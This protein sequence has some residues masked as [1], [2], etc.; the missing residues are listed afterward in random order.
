MGDFG[1]GENVLKEV[2]LLWFVKETVQQ[3]FTLLVD[4]YSSDAQARAVAQRLSAQ[5]G[6]VDFP[7]AFQ[8]TLFKL[9]RIFGVTDSSATD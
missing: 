7:E 2:H 5:A 9:I 6:F 3:D 8:V 1:R 4:I